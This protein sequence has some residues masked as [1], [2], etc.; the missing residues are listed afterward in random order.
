M[1]MLELFG[2]SFLG[3]DRRPHTARVRIVLVF[4]SHSCLSLCFAPTFGLVE[5]Q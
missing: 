5:R 3:L 2:R 1:G 4:L